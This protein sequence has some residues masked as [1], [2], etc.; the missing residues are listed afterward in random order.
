MKARILRIADQEKDVYEADE[1]KSS[2]PTLS[3]DTNLP[4]MNITVVLPIS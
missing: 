3:I 1:S 2:R 4:R